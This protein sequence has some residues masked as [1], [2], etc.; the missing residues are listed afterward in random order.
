MLAAIRRTRE[1]ARGACSVTVSK[2]AEDSTSE[3]PHAE[4]ES[5]KSES[6]SLDPRRIFIEARRGS[7]G[8]ILST[9]CAAP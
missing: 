2:A 4:S 5:V 9:R 8:S 1:V 7:M 6:S 3:P